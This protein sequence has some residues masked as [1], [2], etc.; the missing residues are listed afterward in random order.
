MRRLVMGLVVLLTVAAC[1]SDDGAKKDDDQK[2]AAASAAFAEFTDG[3]KSVK[4]TQDDLPKAPKPFTD[5]QVRIFADEVERVLNLSISADVATLS[6]E[7]A[8]S[9][10]TVEQ[11]DDTSYAM[12]RDFAEAY[13]DHRWEWNVASRFE[14][15]PTEQA[16]IV[17]YVWAVES[18][19]PENNGNDDDILYVTLQAHVVQTIGKA[20]DR[21]TFLTR[22]TVS[23][24]GYRPGGGPDWWPYLA[25]ES[26]PYG[27]A[28][29]PLY[30]DALLVPETDAEALSSDLAGAK[31]SMAEKSV[32]DEEW[33]NVSEVND[34]A[35]GSCA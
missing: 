21:R 15:A 31:V 2:P 8:V 14:Q 24:S 23:M 33:P 22:R 4:I 5:A 18:R 19:D 10:V 11:F 35:E 1:G 9:A 3:L 26:H 27:N 12:R 34:R 17:K 30:T 16:R 6:P 28:P 13:G 20:D 29:C 25:V 32:I 7:D